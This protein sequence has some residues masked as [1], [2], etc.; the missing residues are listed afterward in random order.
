M[1]IFI[2]KII[3]NITAFPVAAVLRTAHECLLSGR[4]FYFA[5]G[6]AISSQRVVDIAVREGRTGWRD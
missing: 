4:I 2:L 3:M 1:G 6:Q 5:T